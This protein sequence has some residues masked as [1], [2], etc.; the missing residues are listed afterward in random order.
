MGLLTEI[1]QIPI[2]IQDIA[3]GVVTV[4]G[5]DVIGIIA[6]FIYFSIPFRLVLG[7]IKTLV[8]GYQGACIQG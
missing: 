4:Y 6:W 8:N 5:L 1:S 3:V 7:F 2:I